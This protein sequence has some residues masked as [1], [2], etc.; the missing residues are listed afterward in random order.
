MRSLTFGRDTNIPEFCNKLRLTVTELFNISDVA[1][2]DKIAM[3]DVISKLDVTVKDKVKVL[4]LAGTC[5]L[6]S[7]L[8]LA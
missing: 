2:I 8:E 5:R 1:T 7:F 3:N 4:Q 6:E